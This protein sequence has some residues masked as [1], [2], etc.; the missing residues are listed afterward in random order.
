MTL[1]EKN[2]VKEAFRRGEAIEF[3]NCITNNDIWI[4]ATTPTWSWDK[5]NYRVKSKPK[6][7]VTIEKWLCKTQFGTYKII[8]GDSNYLST[9]ESFTFEKLLET[10]E[11]EL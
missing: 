11:V 1:R 3:S 8:E 5:Y 4:A 10:Y 6:Q 7:T 2:D 9:L